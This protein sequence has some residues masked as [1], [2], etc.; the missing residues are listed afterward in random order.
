MHADEFIKQVFIPAFCQFFVKFLSV[1]ENKY[2]DFFLIRF[3]L[4]KHLNKI[5]KIYQ[6]SDD[7]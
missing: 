1:S 3:I 7:L 5:N 2:I 4:T 6:G